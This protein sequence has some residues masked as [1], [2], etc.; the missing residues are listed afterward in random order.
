MTNTSLPLLSQLVLHDAFNDAYATVETILKT[1]DP[2][3]GCIIPILGPTRVGKSGIVKRLIEKAGQANSLFPQKNVVKASLPP[4]T[5]GKDIYGSILRSLH[6]GRIS[7]AKTD[8][9]RDRLYR[10]IDTLKIEVIVLDEVNHLVERGTNLTSRVAAGHLKTLV[11]ETGINLVLS[12][13][14]RFQRI[15]DENEQLLDRASATVLFQPYD[16]QDSAERDAFCVAVDAAFGSLEASGFGVDLGFEDIVRRLYGAS[17][18]RV[19]M[20]LRVLKLAALVD[21]TPRS[22]G[23]A[24]FLRAARAI[25]QFGIPAAAFFGECEPDEV[26][27]MRSFAVVMSEAGLK[28]NVES[29]AGLGVVWDTQVA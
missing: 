12:G 20:M 22:L 19:P 7:N 18:G 29:L 11:D 16:W 23:L 10:A 17:G 27:L 13:L 9:C 2:R 25:Q 28:F 1:K 21:E 3:S 6:S 26:E 14:P 15:L 24:D 4:Q 8:V 5:N